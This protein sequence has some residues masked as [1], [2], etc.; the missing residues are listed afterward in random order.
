MHWDVGSDRWCNNRGEVYL[1]RDMWEEDG[2]S[3]MEFSS[4]A[5]LWTTKIAF[6]GRRTRAVAAPWANQQQ[7]QRLLSGSG[8][9][10]QFP[11]H[12]NNKF[13]V[14]L[15]QLPKGRNEL[16]FSRVRRSTTPCGDSF[17]LL[18]ASKE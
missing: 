6:D 17:R 12:P 10:G 5:G 15:V 11:D 8:C 7:P 16:G 1:P 3:E 2:H 13:L 14:L 4:V 18:I 9:L